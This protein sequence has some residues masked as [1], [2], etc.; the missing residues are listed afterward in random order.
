V[1]FVKYIRLLLQQNGLYRAHKQNTIT[2]S[3]GFPLR[4]FV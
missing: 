4:V 3:L 1:P 2:V